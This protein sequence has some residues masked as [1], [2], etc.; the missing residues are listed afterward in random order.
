MSRKRITFIVV[1]ICLS[2]LFLS[3]C[4]PGH[5]RFDADNQAGFFWGLWHGIIVWISFF[6]GLFLGGDY[7]I[8]ESNNTGW[9]YNL[10][11]LIGMSSAIG[12]TS[13]GLLNIKIN[14]PK[15]IIIKEYRK[16]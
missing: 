10:G 13:K 4:V 11:F 5:E 9:L 12:G 2:I 14:N 6:I 1:L 8:Y 16:D 15:K 3:G 7:T